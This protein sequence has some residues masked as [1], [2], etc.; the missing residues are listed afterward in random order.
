MSDAHPLEIL[1][2]LK[3]M[4][5]EA[6]GMA[7][8]AHSCLGQEWREAWKRDWPEDFERV[9]RAVAI[10]QRAGCAPKWPHEEPATQLTKVQK[11][12]LAAV[13]ALQPCGTERIA[14]AARIS[15][16]WASVNLLFLR[17]NGLIDARKDGRRNVY[18]V[19]KAD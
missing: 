16:N 3:E 2:S 11:V 12:V 9:M 1:A 14:E 13:E 8:T 4:T 7:E 19:A 15:N 6:L 5:E 17:H 18:S 10:L